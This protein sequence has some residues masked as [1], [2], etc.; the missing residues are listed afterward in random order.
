MEDSLWDVWPV[1]SPWSRGGSSKAEP[2]TWGNFSFILLVLIN[3]VCQGGE[4]RKSS[5][6]WGCGDREDPDPGESG[7]IVAF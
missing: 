2:E 7:A 1:Q 4:F 6:Q 5:L 3:G